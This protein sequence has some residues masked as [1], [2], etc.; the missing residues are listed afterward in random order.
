MERI[1]CLAYGYLFGLIQ[2]GYIYGKICHVDIRQHGS[3]NSGAT[4]TLRVLGVKAALI[5]FLGDVFKMVAAGLLTRG[6]FASR[7][8]MLY[9]LLLYTGAGV[10]LGHNYPFYMKFRGGKGIAATAGIIL[11]LDFRLTLICLV[12]F[13]VTVAVT[14]YVSLGSLLISSAFCICM[15]YWGT[16]GD[17]GLGGQYLFEFYLM[18][19][20]IAAMAFW[21]HRTNI[22]RLLHGTE[23]KFKLN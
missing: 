20:L 3:G 11:S 16:K 15:I 9:L 22:V 12:V 4:N 17:Y 7:P 14:R 13:V 6:L 2:T 21:R 10:I 8:E 1:I 23:H 19:V 18:S 5:V